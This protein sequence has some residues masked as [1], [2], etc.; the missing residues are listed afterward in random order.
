MTG[1]DNAAPKP[2]LV[3]Q[4]LAGDVEVPGGNLLDEEQVIVFH[5]P[6]LSEETVYLGHLLVTP[7]RHCPDFAELD[8]S[9]TAAV[10]VAIATCAAALKAVGAERVY[11]A[12]VGHRIEHLHVHVLARW[13]GTPEEIPWHSVDEWAGARRGAALEIEAMV[14]SLHPSFQAFADTAGPGIAK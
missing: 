10:G 1:P 11:V 14:A 4:E 12:N 9:G 5:V 6:P 7:R 3:C 8:R 2:C 13:P